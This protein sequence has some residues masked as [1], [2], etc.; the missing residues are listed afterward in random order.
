MMTPTEPAFKRPDGIGPANRPDVLRG[1]GQLGHRSGDGRAS[2]GT[3][4]ECL[5]IRMAGE[6]HVEDDMAV[7]A[8][9][10]RAQLPL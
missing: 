3:G 2:Y 6:L 8:R 7:A 10:S 4:D 1:L 9:P 5:R